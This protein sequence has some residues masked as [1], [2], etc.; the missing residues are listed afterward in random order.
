MHMDSAMAKVHPGAH[1]AQ[2]GE[3][4]HHIVLTINGPNK[5]THSP[6]RAPR[7]AGNA[8]L[9]AMTHERPRRPIAEA[10]RGRPGQGMGGREPSVHQ[11][12]MQLGADEA[13]PSSSVDE[14]KHAHI[15]DTELR[16]QQG[17]LGGRGGRHER[18]ASARPTGM[19]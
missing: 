1:R 16:A 11:P 10:Q 18:H 5:G 14:S 4:Q 3:A 17:G 19:G 13:G 9:A 7:R 6:Q 12:L 15:A 8:E 2:P